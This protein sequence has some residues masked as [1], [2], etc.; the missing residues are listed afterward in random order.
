MIGSSHYELS[1]IILRIMSDFLNYWLEGIILQS[2]IFYLSI[3]EGIF[4]VI[5][6]RRHINSDIILDNH[7]LLQSQ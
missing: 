1:G 3:I 6:L 4:N 7:L 5:I 2:N